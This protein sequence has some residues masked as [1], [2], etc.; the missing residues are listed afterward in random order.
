[1]QKGS[2][3]DLEDSIQKPPEDSSVTD[4][5]K[6]K[7][8]QSLDLA[9]L[10][11]AFAEVRTTQETS[12]ESKSSETAASIGG[13]AFSAEVRQ[14]AEKESAKTENDIYEEVF[15]DEVNQQLLSNVLKQEGEIIV[16]LLRQERLKKFSDVWR[17]AN[18]DYYNTQTQKDLQLRKQASRVVAQSD[19]D[20]DESDSTSPVVDESNAGQLLNGESPGKV[21]IQVASAASTNRQ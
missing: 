15:I 19:T 4:S 5:E 12:E 8:K 13:N 18:L 10:K 14:T 21:L 16:V 11:R 17:H 3:F 2:I 1:M 20:S 7:T 9:K 6:E